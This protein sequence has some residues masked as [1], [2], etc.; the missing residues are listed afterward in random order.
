MMEKTSEGVVLKIKVRPSS[1]E[2]RFEQRPDGELILEIKSAP[3]RGE[4]NTEILKRLKEIFRRDVSLLRGH[5]SRNKL[6]L[7]RGADIREI[8]DKL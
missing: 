4:A 1:R 2:F 8:K 5:K 3:E 7:I 6:V